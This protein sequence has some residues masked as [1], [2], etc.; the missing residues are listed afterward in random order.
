MAAS[1]A[2][3]RPAQEAAA[4][5]FDTA[6]VESPTEIA[7]ADVSS[8]PSDWILQ[9]E[10]ELKSDREP[11]DVRQLG[12]GLLAP[13]ENETPA[14]RL[15]RDA[16]DVI[17]DRRPKY[18]GPLHHFARTVGMINAAFADVLKRPLT[19]ADW[20]VVMT[21]DKV[22]RHMGPSKTTDTPID[23]AGYAACLAECE[24]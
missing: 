13:Q 4:R 14:E 7:D 20:A 3:C 9:G 16:I 2:G 10:R 23:L 19:P 5:C 12:D 21:L 18:G 6:D 24:T 17:R 1:L 8:I 11:I 22:S 15:L